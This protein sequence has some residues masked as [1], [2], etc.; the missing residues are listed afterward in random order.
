MQLYRLSLSLDGCSFIL[1]PNPSTHHYA[2][3][4]FPPFLVPYLSSPYSSCFFHP[5]SVFYN[6]FLPSR[7]PLIV[8]LYSQCLSSSAPPSRCALP[9]PSF[10]C[11]L[12]ISRFLISPANCSSAGPFS[13]RLLIR[14]K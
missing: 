2:L 3:P 10:L 13:H 8:T 12:I 1:L 6:P 14:G 7:F 5:A 9:P 11:P 4:I